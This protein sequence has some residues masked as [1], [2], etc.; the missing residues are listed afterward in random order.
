MSNQYEYFLNVL[1]GLELKRQRLSH[2]ISTEDLCWKSQLDEKEIEEFERGIRPISATTL[3]SLCSAL[4]IS[5]DEFYKT[6]LD[7]INLP[8]TSTSH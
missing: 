4:D 5:L 3:Y 6:A 8:L 7:E 1:L 2:S